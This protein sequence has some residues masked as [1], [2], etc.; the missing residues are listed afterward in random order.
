M[1]NFRTVLLA[2]LFTINFQ[3]AAFAEEAHD[4]NWWQGN[5]KIY[6][7]AY[8]LGFGDG[9]T[10]EAEIWQNSLM[11]VLP[12][13]FNPDI[14]KLTIDVEAEAIRVTN[15]GENITV[16]QMSDG[17]DTFYNDY[18]N[19]LIPVRHAISI[20]ILSIV[21]QSPD[22]IQKLTENLRKQSSRSLNSSPK[23]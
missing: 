20:V 15:L 13:K 10:N 2:I 23:P 19:R 4:G 22:V 6:K 5:S 18:R 9:R 14:T 7:T 3:V 1:N 17:I 12:K 21:G 11:H 16:G 8:I